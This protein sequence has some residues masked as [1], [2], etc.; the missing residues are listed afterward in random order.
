VGLLSSVR[1]S[2]PR[3]RPHHSKT[4]SE[5]AEQRIGDAVILLAHPTGNNFVRETAMALLSADVLTELHLGIAACGGNGFA[6][7]SRLPGMA[8]IRRRTYDSRFSPVDSVGP[9]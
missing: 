5:G 3:N 9:L 4:N 1:I 2:Q 8:E 7:L 6:K